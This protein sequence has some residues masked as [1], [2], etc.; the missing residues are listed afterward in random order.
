MTTKKS[1]KTTDARE[2][3]YKLL[4]EGKPEM[5]ALLEEERTNLDVAEQ[6]VLLRTEAGLSQ[7]ALANKIGTT[8][9]AISRLESADYEGHS[10]AMLRKIATALNKRVQIS[11]LP[12]EVEEVV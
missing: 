12:L 2:I 9:S 5:E 3:L 8:A 1:R 4:V 11:F 6:I 7:Q 10:L